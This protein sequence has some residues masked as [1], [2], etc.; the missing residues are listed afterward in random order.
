MRLRRPTVAS[1]PLLA[2]LVLA[3]ALR[4]SGLGFGL[5]HPPHSDERVFVESVQQMMAAGDLDHRYYEYPGLVFY[6]LMP[7]LWLWPGGTEP[8]PAAYLAAR[9]LIA[10]SGVLACGL[11]HRLGRELAGP[12]PA[13]LAGLLLAVSPVAVET[14]HTLRPDVVLQA[15]ALLALLAFRRL[16]P[17]WR[18]DVLAGA[19]LGLAGAAKFSAALLVPAYLA[20]RLLAPGRFLRGVLVAGVVAVLVF[21]LFTPYAVLH[22]AAFLEGMRVQLGYHY[23]EEARPSV[24]YGGMLLQYLGVA[25]EAVGVPGALLALAGA[26]SARRDWRGWAPA[27]LLFAGTLLVLAT[28]DVRHERFLLPAL[29]LVFLLAGLGAFRLAPRRWTFVAVALLAAALP[30]LASFTFVRAVSGPGTRD[31]VL[32]WASAAAPPRSL[33]V[34]AVPLLGLDPARLEVLEVP[35]LHPENRPQVLEADF[36]LA[37]PFDDPAAVL[38]LPRVFQADRRLRAEGPVITVFSVPPA[39]RP[40]YREVPLERAAVTASSNAA[41]VALAVDGRPETVWRTETSQ[42]AG[43]FL[44]ITLPQAQRVARVELVL[45]DYTRY[46]AREAGVLVSLD[47]VV[48]APARTL[49]GRGSVQTAG[50]GAPSQVLLLAPPVEARALRLLLLRG[51][52]RRWGVAELRL[53]AL[54]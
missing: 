9:A 8:G 37:T 16:G 6:L 24:S 43:D 51:G 30:F 21:L 17:D 39:A 54:P 45:G 36:V 49:P 10:A 28:S 27:A 14:A 20:A 44:Q 13:F 4:F 19:A 23:D 31:R 42:A 11:L 53:W 40:P 41:E 3:A 29:P 50:R 46:A 12:R 33:L 2:I 18:G 38:G 22:P 25:V 1:L 47:G 34:S 5:R 15:L 52:G 7:V 32:D 26:M 48:F 35:R